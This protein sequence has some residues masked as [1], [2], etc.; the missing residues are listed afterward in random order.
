MGQFDIQTG[1]DVA[2]SS[3][4][5]ARRPYSGGHF[6]FVL[7]GAPVP[8]YLRSVE[9]GVVKGEVVDETVGPDFTHFKHLGTVEVEPLSLELGMSM[10][11]PILDWIRASW[12][13]DFGRKTGA[14]IH[15]DFEFHSQI[16]Q[17]FE[18]ALVVET[19]FP[20]LDGAS[21]DPA[22]LTVKLQPERVQLKPGKRE[23][24]RGV[25]SPMQKH[26]SP[27]NFR[28]NIDGLDCSHVA[29]IDSFSVKQNVVQLR[30]GSSRYP[31]LE[32]TGIEFGNLSVTIGLAY[33]DDFRKWYEEYVVRGDKDTRQERQGSIE[34]LG[35]HGVETLF[36]V[37]LQNVG[38]Y[39]FT[40]EKSEANSDSTKRCKVD[41]YVESMD[42][43]YGAGIT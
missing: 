37:N 28:L 20:A 41:L 21:T 17:W 8:G 19:T 29:K 7:D 1:L 13:R 15:T 9:G 32:P 40:I 2:M 23:P 31:E 18:D 11:R 35:P 36:T 38:I 34:F 10:S 16:E 39:G 27:S 14:V 30:V 6:V 25:Y 42:L 12:K 26:W 43:E 24:V 4:G 33:A 22:Y 5:I 3:L